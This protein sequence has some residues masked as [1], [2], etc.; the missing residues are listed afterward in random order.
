MKSLAIGELPSVSEWLREGGLAA[1]LSE[2]M[3]AR[4]RF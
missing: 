2:G 1:T 4:E 3:E